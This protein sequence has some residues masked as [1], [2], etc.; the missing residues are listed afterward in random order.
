MPDIYQ[1]LLTRAL[2]TYRSAGNGFH[3]DQNAQQ[4]L[5]ALNG[6]D[7]PLGTLAAAIARQKAGGYANADAYATASRE[8]L[9]LI[10]A[11][12]GTLAAAASAA[13]TAD[14]AKTARAATLDMAAGALKAKAQQAADAALLAAVDAVIKQARG[15]AAAAA[16]NATPSTSAAA[17]RMTSNATAADAQATPPSPPASRTPPGTSGETESLPSVD[18]DDFAAWIG[19]SSSPTADREIA[20]EIAQLSGLSGPGPG[21]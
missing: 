8:A 9:L 13:A 19:E 15:D 2:A 5:A 18:P 1:E 7:Q 12:R 20:D 16:S 14:R 10:D 4:I 21:L 11:Q 17:P 3:P 6:L